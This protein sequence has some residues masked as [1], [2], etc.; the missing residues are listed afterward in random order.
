LRGPGEPDQ[1]YRLA[2]AVPN[3][4]PQVTCGR[5][6]KFAVEGLSDSLRIELKPFGI[7]VIIIEPGPIL[8]EW[9]AIARRSMLKNSAGTAYAN[10]AKSV[11]RLLETADSPRTASGPDVVARKIVQAVTAK[12]P[13][14]RY[15][16]GKGAGTIVRARKVLPD[17][18]LDA[19]ISRT[20]Q[21]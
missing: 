6:A 15:P 12:N 4:D 7:D 16:V 3:R 18:A 2:W 14:A 19:V 17:A 13:R 20:Y 21:R 11:A 1:R 5:A 8:T 9:N 10:Q